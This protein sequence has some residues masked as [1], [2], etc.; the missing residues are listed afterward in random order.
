MNRYLLKNIIILILA[1]ANLFLLGSLG[2]RQTAALR[3]RERTE[4]Q[5]VS[6]F[7]ADGMELDQDLISWK[8]PP[9]S[10]SLTRNLDREREAA[11]FLLGDGAVQ[12]GAHGG[13]YR[14]TSLRGSAQFRPNGGFDIAGSLSGGDG[15]E[16]CREFCRRF[17]YDE[18]A[19]ILDEEYSGTGSAVFRLG[20]FPVYN[21]AVTF[22]LDHGA[23]LAVSGT[24]LPAEGA[25][26]EE[27]RT[28]LSA[29]AALTVFQQMRRESYTVVSAVTDLTPC[30]E[31]QGAASSTTSLLPAWCV[32][33]DVGRYYVNCVTGAV[34]TR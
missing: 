20:K 33:T 3:A 16:L 5:L 6:L 18:P 34:T 25:A 10:L 4:E 26:L 13:T 31:L 29:A 15:Q 9:S 24:L 17:S 22:T 27:D 21:C 11:T 32:A 2:I 30:Y 23:L 14:Y 28:P 7:A 19:F 1:L 12:S 8:S